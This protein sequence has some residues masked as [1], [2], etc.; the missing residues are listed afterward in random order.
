MPIFTCG[1]MGAK[2]MRDFFKCY[3]V[4]GTRRLTM[5]LTAGC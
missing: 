2:G 4:L 3:V 1:E 5:K